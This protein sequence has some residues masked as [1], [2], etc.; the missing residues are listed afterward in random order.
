MNILLW[1]LILFLFFYLADKCICLVYCKAKKRKDAQKSHTPQQTSSGITTKPSLASKIKLILSG[2][3]RYSVIR[4]GRIP[5]HKYRNWVLRH[6][7]QMELEKNVVVY[8]GFEIRAP[9]NIHIGEGTVVGDDC[10]LDGRNGIKIGKNVNISTGV[11][12]WTEQ[13]DVNDPYFESNS[14]GGPVIVDDRAWLSARTI[15]LPQTHI[16]EGA[17]LAAGAIATKDLLPYGIYGGI[18]AKKIGDRNQNLK[19]EFD[20]T[21]LPF[22]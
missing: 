6:I 7:Y 14:S 13:H 5:C 9:W 12:I 21:Y 20:G 10:K 17:V 15:L 3:I 4:L 11:W 16:G 1:I 22:Y 2:W 18:P 8:G 19:Y